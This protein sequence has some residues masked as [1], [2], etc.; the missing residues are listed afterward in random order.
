MLRKCL[1]A[2]LLLCVYSCAVAQERLIF[3]IDLVRHGDR[4]P[5]IESSGMQKIWPQGFGQLTP[6]GMRQEFELGA[7]LRERYITQYH[8]LPQYYDTNTMMVRSSNITRTMMSAQSLLL[9][10]Y[11]LDTGPSLRN[12]RKALPQ[13]FQPIPINTVPPEQDNLLVPKHNK[14]QYKALLETYIFNNPEWIKKERELSPHYRTWSEVFNVEINNLV[15][16]IAVADRLY[17]ET[18]Y[19]IKPPANL[20]DKQANTIM[21]AGQWA[22]LQI[23]NHPKYGSVFGADLAEKINDELH[24]AVQQDRPLKYLLFVAHDTTLAA[25][26]KI[27]G[28]NIED[29]PP[30]ASHINY[31]LFDMGASQYE[32]RVTYNQKPLF[33][34]HCAGTCN[35]NQFSE[36]LQLAKA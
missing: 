28:Q 26:L 34:K 17:I 3:A 27:L 36:L 15:D 22:F 29:L 33:I 14:K 10:L 35:L 7:T 21:N 8:L 20:D 13:G 25:Q 30:Y 6:Q 1:Y 24:L 18:L 16:L 32:V 4:T 11:P 31:S 19:D 2:A 5:L 9:G 12:G 23:I